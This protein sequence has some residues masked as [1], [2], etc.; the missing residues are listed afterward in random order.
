MYHNA[1]L[2]LPRAAAAPGRRTVKSPGAPAR[3][4]LQGQP[5]WRAG[6]RE[7]TRGIARP[8]RAVNRRA[9]AVLPVRVRARR[10]CFAR[11]NDVADG[12]E[13]VRRYPRLRR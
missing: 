13:R 3:R 2:S 4:C 6:G 1:R 10:G 12:R 9:T 11:E 8:G 5:D 7:E